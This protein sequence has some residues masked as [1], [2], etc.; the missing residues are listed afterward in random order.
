MRFER[1]GLIFQGRADD[2][3]KV[4]GRRIELGEIEAALQN[5]PG[6]SAAAAAVRSTEAGNSVIVG[7][8][9]VPDPAAEP[10]EEED[11]LEDGDTPE[12]IADFLG[13]PER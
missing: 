13:E 8:V 3:V 6:V 12:F 2:Q 7:Y 10:G 9:A 5:L 11:P 4:G 1:A